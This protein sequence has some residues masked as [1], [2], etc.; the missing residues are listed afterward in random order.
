MPPPK[1]ATVPA[2]RLIF[3]QYPVDVYR[4]VIGIGYHVGVDFFGVNKSE[5]IPSSRLRWMISERLNFS[6]GMVRS[7]RRGSHNV[8]GLLHRRWCDVAVVACGP[9]VAH[10]SRSPISLYTA[11]STGSTEE[12]V[13]IVSWARRY[14]RLQGSCFRA[15]VQQFKI[16][17]PA[18]AEQCV[19]QGNHVPGVSVR[20]Y[21]RFITLMKRLNYP[22]GQ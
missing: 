8:S 11:V 13:S 4:S 1:P 2:G 22:S 7:S 18:I 19:Q 5:A 3:L 21:G 17:Y 9:S 6:P 16:R 15:F 20:N 10:V 12:K 14:Q